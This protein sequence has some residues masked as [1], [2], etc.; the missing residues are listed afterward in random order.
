MFDLEIG[1]A[2]DIEG[3]TAKTSPNAGDRHIVNFTL[4]EAGVPAESPEVPT[5]ETPRK[6]G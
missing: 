3:Q 2:G 4:E 1:R 5:G 6:K